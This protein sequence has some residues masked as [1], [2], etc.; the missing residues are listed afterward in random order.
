MEHL[1]KCSQLGLHVIVCVYF[2]AD[3]WGNTSP[4]FY[5]RPKDMIV[6]ESEDVEFICDVRGRPK[7]IVGWEKVDGFLPPGRLVLLYRPEE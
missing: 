7:P 5:K 2:I 6:L 3:A 4:S 1:L